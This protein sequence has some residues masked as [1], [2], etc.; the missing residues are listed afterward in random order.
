MP[1]S[2][3]KEPAKVTFI[4]P[5][6]SCLPPSDQAGSSGCITLSG[7]R[8]P[9]NSFSKATNLKSRN[10]HRREETIVLDAQLI[11]KDLFSTHPARKFNCGT[12]E[13]SCSNA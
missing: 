3:E 10:S 13:S 8:L 11:F 2:E 9:T 7:C 1:T 6:L 5:R 4:S 12:V